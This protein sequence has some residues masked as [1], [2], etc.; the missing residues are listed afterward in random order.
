MLVINKLGAYTFE[1][2]YLQHS[3]FLA[4][5]NVKKTISCIHWKTDREHTKVRVLILH[6]TSKEMS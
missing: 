3:H 4:Y 6:Q 5:L 1:Q 2:I